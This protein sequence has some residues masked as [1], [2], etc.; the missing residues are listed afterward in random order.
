M[1]APSLSVALLETFKQHA[2]HYDGG[3]MDLNAGL[4]A[5][6]DLAS[7]LIAEIPDASHRMTHMQALFRVIARDTWRK[8]AAQQEKSQGRH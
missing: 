7:G 2:D 8:A 6:A 3:K 1:I 4:A 5:I